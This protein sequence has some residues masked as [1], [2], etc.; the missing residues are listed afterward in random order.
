MDAI[1]DQARRDFD[2]KCLEVLLNWENEVWY[3]FEDILRD[4]EGDPKPLGKDEL[5]G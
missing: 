1:Y 4:L 2:P 3:P 5:Q